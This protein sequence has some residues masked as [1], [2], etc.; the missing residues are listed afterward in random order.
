VS[1]RNVLTIGDDALAVM[2]FPEIAERLGTTRSNVFCAYRS[3]MKKLRRN[4]VAIENMRALAEELERTR[5]V[6]I[7]WFGSEEE[8]EHVVEGG[9]PEAVSAD[10]MR[11]PRHASAHALLQRQVPHGGSPGS[12][13]PPHSDLRALRQIDTQTRQAAGEVS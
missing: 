7:A 9:L 11:E 10:G 4:T 5:P 1:R 2:T 6:D 3:G 13:R 12:K 8:E